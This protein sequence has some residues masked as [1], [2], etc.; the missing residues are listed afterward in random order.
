MTTLFSFNLKK[1]NGVIYNNKKNFIVKFY[2]NTKSVSKK[3]F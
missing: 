1:N 3:K 2:T